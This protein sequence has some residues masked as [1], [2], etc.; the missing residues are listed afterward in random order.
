MECLRST[1]LRSCT[2]WTIAFSVDLNLNLVLGPKYGHL[3]PVSP[4]FEPT[5]LSPFNPLALA[6][7]HAQR[8]LK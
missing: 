4:G 5:I 2:E 8:A 3:V 1:E 7:P 6:R